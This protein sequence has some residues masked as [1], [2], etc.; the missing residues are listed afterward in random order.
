MCCRFLFLADWLSL[1][2]LF[3]K[4]GDYFVECGGAI[5]KFVESHKTTVPVGCE[6]RWYLFGFALETFALWGQFDDCLAS[7]GSAFGSDYMSFDL[8]AFQ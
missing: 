5:S 8:H 3:L 1:G 2:F 4:L 6:A 7:V